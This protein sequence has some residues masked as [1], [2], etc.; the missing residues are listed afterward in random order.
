MCDLNNFAFILNI[1]HKKK[2][3]VLQENFCRMCIPLESIIRSMICKFDTNHLTK[4]IFYTDL[5]M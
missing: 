4:I 1:H 5:S 2:N 3:I